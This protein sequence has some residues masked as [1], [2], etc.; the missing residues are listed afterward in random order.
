MCKGLGILPATCLQ[1]VKIIKYRVGLLFLQK[2]KTQAAGSATRVVPAAELEKWTESFSNVMDNEGG[3]MVFSTFL[4]SEF[5][6]ENMDFWVACQNYKKILPSKMARRAK[7]IYKQFVVAN[8]PNEVNLDSATR[9]E[10]RQ[11]L[12]CVGPTCF[13]KAQRCI[14]ILMEKDSYKRFLKSK[15]IQNLPHTY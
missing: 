2:P 15:L 5:S 10:T 1:S 4:L 8:S 3:R 7:I 13:D 14:Y 12:E 11:N 6:E 9:E